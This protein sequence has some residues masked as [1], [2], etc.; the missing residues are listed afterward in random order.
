MAGRVRPGRAWQD[1]VRKGQAGKEPSTETKMQETFGWKGGARTK[2]LD[3]EAV[4]PVLQRLEAE[5][6]ALTPEDVLTEAQEPASALHGFFTWDDSEAARLHRLAEARDLIRSVTVTYI[7]ADEPARTVRAFVHYGEEGVYESVARV[8]GDD[9]KRA[10]LLAMALAD[11]A[12][13]KR[14]YADLK[15]LAKVFRAIEEATA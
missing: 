13:W 8:L 12:A 5:H 15:E 4:V 2:H 1:T 14:K 7:G 3:L 9:E 6:G 11:L 10:A